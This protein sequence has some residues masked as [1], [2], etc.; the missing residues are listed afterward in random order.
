MSNNHE[1]DSVRVYQAVTF[2]KANETFFASRQINARK[3]CE[4]KILP[5]LMSVS[6]K[7]AK[8][9]ILVPFTNISCIYLKSPIKLEQE[10]KNKEEIEVKAKIASTKKST[11]KR[12]K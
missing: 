3:P 10:A 11:V 6:I 5:E 7:S 8:D 1:I 12:P 4:I 9:H 2:E